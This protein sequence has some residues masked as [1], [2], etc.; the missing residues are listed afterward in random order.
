M[1]GF[2]MD[3]HETARGH[4]DRFIVPAVVINGH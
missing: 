3:K 2:K 4:N 1:L